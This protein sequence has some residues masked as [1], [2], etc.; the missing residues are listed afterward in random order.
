MGRFP[1]FLEHLIGEEIC[2]AA[3]GALAGAL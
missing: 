3:E 1:D 2:A